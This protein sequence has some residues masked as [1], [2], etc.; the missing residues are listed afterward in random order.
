MTTSAAKITAKP[1]SILGVTASPRKMQEASAPNTDSSDSRI[2]ACDA[3]AMLWPMFCRLIA[4]VVEKT[5]RY[6]RLPTVSMCMLM[7]SP[8]SK[9]R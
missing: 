5:D 4:I 3:G 1:S 8:R 7:G 9:S 2:D 6:S